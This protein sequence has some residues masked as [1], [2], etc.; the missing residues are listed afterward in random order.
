VF[1]Q[2]GP[3]STPT[4]ISSGGGEVRNMVAASDDRLYLA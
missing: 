4:L 1:D 2:E 3:F